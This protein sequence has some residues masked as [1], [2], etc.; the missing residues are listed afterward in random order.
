MIVNI[1]RLSSAV[2]LGLFAVTAQ[3]AQ[4]E[5]SQA[6]TDFLTI[7]SQEVRE[8]TDSMNYSKYIMLD[9]G[10]VPPP[11]EIDPVSRVGKVVTVARDIVALGE[12]LYRL[13]IKG[14]PTNTTSYAPISVVPKEN[15]VV[16]DVLDLDYWETPIKRTY[17]VVYK[18]YYDMDV[19]TF[20]YAVIF[21]YG[22]S[23]NGKGKYLTGVQIVPDYARTLFGFDFEATMR[24]GGIQNN[25]TKANPLAGA[26]ILLEY[27]VSSIM[28]VDSRVDSFFVTGAGKLKKL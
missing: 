24:L 28:N 26:T 9:D 15:N 3:A 5:Y 16:V 22:A 6:E 17:E 19:V 1:K 21:A 8:V 18:N 20:R 10:E 13:V 12:D 4:R 14:K 11:A 2:I 27:T 23:Y 25:G 7:K